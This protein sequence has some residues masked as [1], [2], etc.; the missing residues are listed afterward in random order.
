M[1]SV[2]KDSDHRG[3]RAYNQSDSVAGNQC[4]GLDNQSMDLDYTSAPFEQYADL[5]TKYRF[6]QVVESNS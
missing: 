6:S 1:G 4:T 5:A 2:P 3:Y